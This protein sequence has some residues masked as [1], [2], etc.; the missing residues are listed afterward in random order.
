VPG[1]VSRAIGDTAEAW[2]A[3]SLEHA[4]YRITDRNF[5]VK[6]GELDL[7]ARAPDGTVCFVE[8]RAR[9][10]A[11]HGTPAETVGRTKQQRLIRAAQVYLVTKLRGADV[12]CRFDVIEIEGDVL[13]H[14]P[15]AF[16]LPDG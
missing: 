12:A 3:R 11:S 15:D 8:V 4:G 16:R 6:G 13:R 14:I 1:P 10:D 7:V 5:T 2:A 9:R